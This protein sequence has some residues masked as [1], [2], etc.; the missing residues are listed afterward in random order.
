MGTMTITVKAV[1]IPSV[2]PAGR[3][4]GLERTSRSCLVVC[5]TF[6]EAV[7]RAAEGAVEHP[8][9]AFPAWGES[10]GSIGAGWLHSSLR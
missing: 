2:H 4:N 7:L 9:H 6:C 3:A 5:V 8:V 1:S 10:L